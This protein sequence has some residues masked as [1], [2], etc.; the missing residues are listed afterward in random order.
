MMSLQSPRYGSH[1]NGSIHLIF[2]P[3][4]SG[5]STELIRR[6]K[7]YSIAD[8][9]CVVIKYSKDTRY[10][11]GVRTHD[12]QHLSAVA[13]SK[14]EEIMDSLDDIDVIGIDEGQ[15]FP[16]VVS[17]SETMANLGKHVIIAALDGTFQ[18]KPFNNILE[19]V[20][21][22]E[23]V[24]KLNAVCM[25]CK[26]EEAAFSKRIGA[27]TEVEVIGGTDK[28]LAVCRECYNED[29]KPQT[30]PSTQTKVTN[31]TPPTM[32]AKAVD[33]RFESHPVAK[34]LFA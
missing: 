17:F 3:M 27:E 10:G 6:M 23:K 31:L 5:K 9:D 30:P 14:L 21:L 7:R 2:G 13:C 34:K 29:K 20:P 24:V 4:F 16:D 11:D 15:F 22:A 18:R 25:Q 8:H 32:A 12:S 1:L 28:Y 26:N 19:L 33:S